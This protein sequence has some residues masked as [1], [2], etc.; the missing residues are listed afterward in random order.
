MSFEKEKK[1]KKGA[2]KVTYQVNLT[3]SEVSFSSR[4]LKLAGEI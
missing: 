2:T 4:Q 1:E 3:V